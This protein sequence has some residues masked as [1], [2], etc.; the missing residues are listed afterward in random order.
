MQLVEASTGDSDPTGGQVLLVRFGAMGEIGRF[1]SAES[2]ASGTHVVVETARGPQ[3]GT[4]IAKARNGDSDESS[5]P[6]VLR[7]AGEEDQQAADRLRLAS[8]QA[9]PE[10]EA[11]IREWSVDLQLIDLEQTL[12]G[13]K[14]ILYVLNERGPESTKLALRAAAAGF[15]VIEVQPVGSDGVIANVGGGGCGSCR[16]KS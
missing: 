4:V 16:N 9:F 6:R 10:W 3:L 13:N 12:D 11:R 2:L 1:R 7:V 5:S 8:Q 14:Q 15:G